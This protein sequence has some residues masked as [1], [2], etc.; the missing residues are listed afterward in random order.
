MTTL[1]P[2]AVLPKKFGQ[3]D[4]SDPRCCDPNRNPHH[5]FEADSWQLVSWQLP[6]FVAV[7]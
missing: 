4:D 6:A 7:I 1:T 3:N 5:T 2:N